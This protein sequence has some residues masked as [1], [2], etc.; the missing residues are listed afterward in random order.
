MP[1]MI[2]MVPT[3]ALITLIRCSG[4]LCFGYLTML[5]TPSRTSQKPKPT[6]TDERDSNNLHLLKPFRFLKG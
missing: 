6:K 5:K 1:I 2:I 3:D 4:K